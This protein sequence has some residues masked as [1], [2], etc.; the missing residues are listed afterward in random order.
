VL[1]ISRIEAGR[2]AATGEDFDLHRLVNGTVAML[3][4]QAQR[5]GL[6]L[7]AHI[8]PQTPFQLHGDAR[9]L[10]QIL[11]NLIGNAVKF[12]ETGAVCLTASFIEDDKRGAW[13]CIDVSDTGIGISIEQ[14]SKLFE[15][16]TQADSSSS[17][18]YGGTGLGLA[19]SRR[20]AE[21]L[22]GTLVLLGS[23]P[24][25][26]STFRL[27]LPLD[28]SDGTEARN[29][30]AP[31]PQA[32]MEVEPDARPG[33]PLD[34]SILL[35]EDTLDTQMLVVRLLTKCGATVTTADN[36]QDAIEKVMAAEASA[37]P[38]D[39]VLMDGQMPVMDGLKATQVLRAKGYSGVIIAL[40]AHAMTDD[41]AKCIEAG[42]DDYATKP[43]K[44]AALCEVIRRNLAKGRCLAKAGPDA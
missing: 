2:L 22:G 29:S 6:A 33:D 3:E 37:Q 21:M 27:T 18:R 15:P 10:R 23:T 28:P 43:V 4:T 30:A 34:C 39:V 13:I 31:M 26:G 41:R 19:I 16:F 12:T 9:H 11:I 5:K 24:G 42:C 44:I 20:L 7:A 1:D 14:R 17:R 8:A 25:K 36:G 38:F 35:A 32:L 40:T